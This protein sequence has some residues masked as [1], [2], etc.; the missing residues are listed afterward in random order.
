[1][2]NTQTADWKLETL[3][4]LENAKW[5]TDTDWISITRFAHDEDSE[6]RYRT[7]ELLA[8][9][10]SPESEQLLLGR[11]NDQDRLVR[12]SA[13]DSL[14]FSKSLETLQ[15]LKRAA[16][17]RTCLVRGY[18]V[19]SLADVQLH[20]ETNPK[21]TI[22]FL[23]KVESQESSDWVRIFLYRSLLI[24]GEYTYGRLLLGMV[25]NRYYKNRCAALSLLEELVAN[26]YVDY[27]PGIKA[28]LEDCISVEQAYSVKLKLEK[29]LK[30]LPINR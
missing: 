20:S 30:T 21:E 24:L 27:L 25:H 18:A 17:D 28:V 3:S 13:C 22:A 5:P 14:S 6:I 26:G 1:M 12:A 10:P 9:F 2:E 19:I 11:L 23:K 15:A 16:E 4:E 8:L 7:C 29:L